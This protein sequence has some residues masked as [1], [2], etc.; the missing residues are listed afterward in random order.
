MSHTQTTSEIMQRI[1]AQ[2]QEK[3]AG[4]AANQEP[5]D[6]KS[7]AREMEAIARLLKNQTSSPAQAPSPISAIA[8]QD[9]ASLAAETA[10]ALTAHREFGQLNPRHPGLHNDAI[11]FGK[12]VMRRSLTWYTRP[13]HMFQGAVV[14]ALQRI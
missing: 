6:A 2:M 7:F 12:K 3:P 11:Q 5:N 4:S 13:M 14:R 8:T 10:T 1:R 9:T